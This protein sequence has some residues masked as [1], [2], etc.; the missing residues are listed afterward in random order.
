MRFHETSARCTALKSFAALEDLTD[1][2]MKQE[3]KVVNAAMS[4]ARQPVPST[5]P[6]PKYK[7]NSTLRL[8]STRYSGG[9]ADCQRFARTAAAS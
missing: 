2:F 8:D 4:H 1:S 3:R 7:M 6:A 5:F 9:S